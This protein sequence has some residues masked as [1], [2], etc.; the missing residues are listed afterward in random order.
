MSEAKRSV[1]YGGLMLGGPAGSPRTTQMSD[2]SPHSRTPVLAPPVSGVLARNG[3]REL[4]ERVEM[5]RRDLGG[6]A[7]HWDPLNR[8]NP[9]L[10]LILFGAT[11]ALSRAGLIKRARNTKAKVMPRR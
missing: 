10:N 6:L 11:A 8:F 1:R 2:R 7:D 9:S 4:C 5:A 3:G